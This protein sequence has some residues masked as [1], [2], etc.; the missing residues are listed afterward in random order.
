MKKTS[1][2]MIVVAALLVFAVCALASSGLKI[3]A[4]VPF[5]FYVGEE[6]LPAGNYLFEMR[7]IGFGSSSSSAVAVYRQDGSLAVMVSTIPDGWG[8][9]SMADGRLHFAR[10]SNTYFLSKIE[11]ADSRASLMATKAERELR[12]QNNR[13]TE[14]VI[15][16]QRRFSRAGNQ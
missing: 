11:G 4:T 16:A 14:T 13:A 5:A 7:A 9:R 8:S 15:I 1:V 3:R 12:A 2:L 10:Y 6:Q